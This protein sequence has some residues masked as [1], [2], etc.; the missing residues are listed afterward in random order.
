ML[1]FEGKNWKNKIIEY[2]TNTKA[3]TLSKAV[4]APN[5]K[6]SKLSSKTGSKII[7]KE[8]KLSLGIG[9]KRFEV[10]FK[11]IKCRKNNQNREKQLFHWV[12]K[13]R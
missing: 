12:T 3:I 6:G 2:L 4:N 9:F 10:I 11:K 1:E 8:G 13:K 7:W 5:F